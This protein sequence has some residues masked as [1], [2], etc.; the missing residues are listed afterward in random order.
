[1]TLIGNLDT[2][3][4]FRHDISE[5]KVSHAFIVEGPK[6]SGKTTL[7]R[8]LS[9]MLMCEGE[10]TPCAVC[11]SCKMILSGEHPDVHEIG[12]PEGK[13]QI[14]VDSVRDLIHDVYVK[15]S[16]GGYSVFIIEDA[17]KMSPQAQN[18]LLQV[19]EEPP[20]KTLFFL[21]VTDRNLI[22]K[23]LLSRARVIRT[24]HLTDT[25]VKKVLEEKYPDSSAL[26]NRVLRLSDNSLGEAIN[27]L[28]NNASANTL[29]LA[30]QYFQ[31]VYEGA[32]LYRLSTI[33]SPF[34][35]MPKEELSMLLTY[36]SAA[37]RDIASVCVSEDTRLMFFSNENEPRAIGERLGLHR[38]VKLFDTCQD[39]L[40]RI[41]AV[42]V[43]S[44]ITLLNTSL[45]NDIK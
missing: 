20:Q 12:L 42:N 26:I 34:K 41:S 7:A 1:M 43:S 25:V 16:E 39:L 14:P 21:L 29:T 27:L 10:N 22:L 33:L 31:S 4:L 38:T 2:L 5:G 17:H 23:T 44:A 19:F 24:E 18:A 37:V 30:T 6:G 11:R 40:R 32:S 15:P 35:A 28:E 8:T 45:A 3:D 36:F 13:T 9:A